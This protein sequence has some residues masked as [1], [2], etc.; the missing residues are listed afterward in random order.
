M[1]VEVDAFNSQVPIFGNVTFSNI[2]G[3]LNENAESYVALACHYDSKYFENNLDF[4]A[5]IDSAVPCALMLNVIKTLQS[6]LDKDKT[7]ISLMVITSA[8]FRSSTIE[9]YLLF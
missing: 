6:R 9:N 2:V 7:D 8:D 1:H 3:K 4:V 5:A